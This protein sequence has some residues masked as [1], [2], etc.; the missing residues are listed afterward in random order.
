MSAVA[1]TLRQDVRVIGLI[2]VAH[3]LSHFYQLV[4]ISA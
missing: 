1:P 4:R 3:G 2:A